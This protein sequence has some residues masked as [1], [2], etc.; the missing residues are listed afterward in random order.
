[1]LN[2]NVCPNCGQLYD[3]EL[4]KCPLCGAAP[5]VVEAENPVQRKR[6]TELERKQRRADRKEAEQEARRRR[7]SDQI[8]QDAEEE[9]LLEEKAARRKEEKR[10]MKEE[11]RA[12]KQG[13]SP[14]EAPIIRRNPA[15]AVPEPVPTPIVTPAPARTVRRPA[16]QERPVLRDRTRVPRVFLVLSTILLTLA[17]VVGGTYLLWKK[18]V[19]KLPVYDKIFN[20]HHGEKSPAAPTPSGTE[21]PVQT[22]APTETE[23][24]SRT[25]APVVTEAPVETEAPTQTEAPAETEAPVVTEAPTTEAPA[26]TEAPTESLAEDAC[27][28]LTLNTQEIVLDHLGALGQIIA[29]TEPNPTRDRKSFASSDESV[30]TVSPVGAVTAVGA[31]SAV[32]TVT[33][34][35]QTAQCTVICDF[36]DPNATTELPP[37][38]VDELI[39]NK[40]DMTF[41]GPRENF[42]LR[43]T[44]VPADTPITWK[45]LDEEICTVDESGHVVAVGRGTTRVIATYGDLSA[46]CWVRC[47]FPEEE[48]DP[49][50]TQAP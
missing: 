48:T 42:S 45:S 44:N 39:L 38:D 31:G 23:A 49:A 15:E 43:I 4:S 12:A 1:M 37:V 34:G 29:T 35:T 41:F 6:I 26:E 19:V 50:A 33:C 24:P 40:D 13:Y 32:I 21:A 8:V 3:T 27:R 18:Q 46:S 30:A 47:R 7:K 16:V 28:V 14:D 22:E 5:Q 9:R 36:E 20:E 2:K 10:R 11:K 17:I 25:E